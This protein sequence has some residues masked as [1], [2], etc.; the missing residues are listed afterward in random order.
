MPKR[1]GVAALI[2][3]LLGC[4]GAVGAQPAP[5]AVSI[6]ELVAL[7]Q[8]VVVAEGDEARRGR[9]QLHA[10]RNAEHIG[11]QHVNINTVAG[12]SSLVHKH[13]GIQNLGR[14]AQQAFRLGQGLGLEEL[15]GAE[16]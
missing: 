8:K 2:S 4:F 9:A 16:Q 7:A 10:R 13:A 3:P 11:R 1:G 12:G 5:V 15:P 14:L 6:F